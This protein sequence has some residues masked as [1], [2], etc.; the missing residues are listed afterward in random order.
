MNLIPDTQNRAKRIIEDFMI[1]ANGVTSRYL[2]SRNRTS[3]RR[4]VRVPKRWDRIVSIADEHGTAL[5]EKPD[6]S[7]T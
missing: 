1:A 5:P 6:A 2:A 7:A 3:I 4:I